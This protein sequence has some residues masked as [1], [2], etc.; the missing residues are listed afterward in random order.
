MI[1]ELVRS[2]PSGILAVPY[3]DGA[4]LPARTLPDGAI[5]EAISP[6]ALSRHIRRPVP[7]REGAGDAATGR[8]RAGVF[9]LPDGDVAA[10]YG[11]RARPL[12]RSGA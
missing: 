3:R 9:L 12:G 7:V 2:H 1:L 4:P 11:A 8:P 10:V 6:S 5:V